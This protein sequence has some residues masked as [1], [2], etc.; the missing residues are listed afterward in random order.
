MSTPEQI[1]EFKTESVLTE[2][3][4]LSPSLGKWAES[5]IDDHGNSLEDLISTLDNATK[6]AKE[7]MKINY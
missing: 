1:N 5:F 4:L 6:F 2:L 3:K 7:Q